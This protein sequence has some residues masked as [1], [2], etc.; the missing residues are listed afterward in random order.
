MAISLDDQIAAAERR[1][2]EAVQRRDTRAQ[3]DAISTLKNLR[4]RRMRRDKRRGLFRIA[5]DAAQVAAFFA[6]GFVAYCIA[7]PLSIFA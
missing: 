6:V 5:A 7:N 4:I 1:A 3:H 2:L